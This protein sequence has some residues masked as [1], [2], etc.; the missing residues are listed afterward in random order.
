[1]MKTYSVLLLAALAGC[2]AKTDVRVDPNVAIPPGAVVIEPNAVA[3]DV[4]P[5]ITVEPNAVAVDASLARLDQR[6]SAEAGEGT[7]V[8]LNL[9]G[10]GWPLAAVA[11]IGAAAVGYALWQRHR[12]AWMERAAGD[13]AAAIK[14]SPKTAQGHVISRL[15][16]AMRC[17]GRWKRWL[18]RK[19]SRV[20]ISP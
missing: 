12:R 9:S 17:E 13:V 20:R 14:D 11:G 16:G 1:M 6:A 10:S 3:V 15:D 2:D 19:G 4:D 5:A 18:D 7:A 8:L